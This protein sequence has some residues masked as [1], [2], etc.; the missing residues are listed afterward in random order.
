MLALADLAALQGR[1]ADAV[2]LADEAMR[3]APNDASVWH[4]RGTLALAAGDA[5]A[6]QEA[7]AKALAIDPRH[8]EARVA[9]AT[10]LMDLGRIDD[11]ADDIRYLAAEHATEPRALYVRAMYLAKRGDE[12]GTREALVQM[13]NSIDQVPRDVL[14]Q[15]AVDLLLL[16]GLGHYSL[17]QREKARQYVEDYLALRPRHVGARR[18]LASILIAQRDYRTAISVLEAARKDAPNDPQVLTLLGS[19]HMARG[20]HNLASG[21]LEQAL[22]ESGGAASV[23][24]KYGLSLLGGGQGELALQHLQQ[25]FKKDPGDAQSGVALAALYMR[26]GEPRLAVETAEAI[27]RRAPG[28]PYTLNLLGAAHL[29][30]GD[31]K[32]A[33][34][35]FLQ[36]A[37]ADP[38]F[39]PS[40]LN[41]GRLDVADGDFAAARGRFAAL[42]KRR[43]ADAQ[44]M[45]ELGLTEEAAGQRADA[46]RWLEKA[47]A[48]DR[49]HIAAGTALVS[50]HLAS[51][52]TDKALG[53]AK[54]IDAAA[55]DNLDALAALGRV[56]ITLGND[57]QAQSV[58]SRMARIAAFDPAW[59][60]QIARYQLAANNRDGAAYSLEKAL[61]GRPDYLPAQILGVELDLRGGEIA[62]AEQRAKG[63]ASKAPNRAI[64]YQLLGDV[65]MARK[66]Y[67]E[68][69]ERYRTALAKE[70]S[71][72]GAIR[73]FGAQLQ[74]GNGKGGIQFL[75]S[76]VRAHP[77]DKVARNMLAEGHL[78][79]G[80]LSAARAALRADSS[81]TGRRLRP[82]ST[83]SPISCCCRATLSRQ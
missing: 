33:R 3:I 60:T 66:N 68:A 34:A 55:P 19:A 22:R 5:K 82:C 74:A 41:L 65:S 70:E 59:Q 71:T 51:G 21:Y 39:A 69:I 12:N 30:A 45:Y 36:A 44:A 26:R 76:W 73:L 48:A 8:L 81:G 77:N 31:R 46:I 83:T 56:Y 50:L 1:R 40:Q 14:K 64:G 52:A 43:P 27:V 25:A 32:G 17:G 18:V 38:A 35:A 4:F 10:L 49:R 15:R 53:A 23:E 62:K 54:E 29:A 67:A 2:A 13:T 37:G 61:S 78:R 9:R 75:E 47:R 6:A 80:N 7:F 16:G 11:V 79:V 42:L 20:Q 72:D 24:A 58:L 57:K 28:N 63:I